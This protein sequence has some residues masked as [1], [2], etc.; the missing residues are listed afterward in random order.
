MSTLHTAYGVGVEEPVGD[1]VL[2]TGSRNVRRLWMGSVVSS[3][4]DWFNTIALCVL[5]MSGHAASAGNGV[6]STVML[7][8]RTTD[9]LRGR[10]FSEGL[11]VGAPRGEYRIPF[12]FHGRRAEDGW[13]GGGSKMRGQ[14]QASQQK[15]ADLQAEGPPAMGGARDVGAQ[16]GRG[17]MLPPSRCGMESARRYWRVP[18]FF[19][20]TP[21]TWPSP[22]V[23][24]REPGTPLSR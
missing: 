4:G 21:S 22:L 19:V 16:P 12:G 8:K 20:V 5:I 18:P 15:R 6:L 11:L 24:M 14:N 2:V 10:V 9:R 7:Q 13:P 1:R 17:Y 3:L 23:M